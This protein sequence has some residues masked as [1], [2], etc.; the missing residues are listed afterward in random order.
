LLRRLALGVRFSVLIIVNKMEVMLEEVLDA[1][2]RAL[3][4]AVEGDVDL[5]PRLAQ[6]TGVGIERAFVLGLVGHKTAGLKERAPYAN[7]DG[8]LGRVHNDDGHC[9]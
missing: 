9:R 5:S 1:A 2:L 8:G 6:P 7:S 3:L 4:V